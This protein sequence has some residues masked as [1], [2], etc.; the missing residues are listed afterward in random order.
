[1]Q[2]TGF[3]G[4]MHHFCLNYAKSSIP[5]QNINLSLTCMEKVLVNFYAQLLRNEETETNRK[6]MNKEVY[7]IGIDNDNRVNLSCDLDEFSESLIPTFSNVI[8]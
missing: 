8:F 5:P 1:M 4:G 6:N 3:V 2:K 7:F